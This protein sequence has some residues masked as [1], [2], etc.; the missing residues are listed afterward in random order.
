MGCGNDERQARDLS[1]VVVVGLASCFGCQLQITNVEEHLTDVLGQID[2]RYWQLASSEPMPEEFDVA[3][4]E[5]AV[6]TEESEATVR[7]LRERAKCVIALGACAATAGIPGIAARNFFKRPSQVYKDVPAA[8]GSMV[9][10]RPVGAVIDVDYTVRCC[11][12]D[13]MDFIDVLQRALYGSNKFDRTGTMCGQCK[14]NGTDCFFDQGQLCLG[15]VTV[16]GC[17]A[18]CVNLGRACNGCRGLSPDANLE[19]ARAACER[20]GVDPDDFDEALALTI[21]DVREAVGG[22][23]AGKANTLTFS[24]EAVRALIG[25]F[26]ARE[27]AGLAELD[28]VVPCDSYSVACLMCE[29]C[30]LRDTRTDLLVAAMDGE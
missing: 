14:R 19:A 10:P 29:H 4:I 6:T 9:V 1:R 17:G 11:P 18:K 22:V 2:L 15:L 21:E 13:T 12:I 23:P 7:K 5:G 28:A 20:A 26:L 3:V 27:G 30:S 25:D 8:C 16:A 24:V